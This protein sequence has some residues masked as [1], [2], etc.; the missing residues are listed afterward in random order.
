[1]LTWW[2][3][4]AQFPLTRISGLTGTIM[5]SPIADAAAIPAASNAIA[6]LAVFIFVLPLIAFPAYSTRRGS[7]GSAFSP[8]SHAPGGGF[9]EMP[10]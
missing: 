3:F 9:G 6:S 1:M 5:P 7:Q 2:Y 8:I 10:G 4:T